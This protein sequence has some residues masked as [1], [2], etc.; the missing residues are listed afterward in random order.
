VPAATDIAIAGTACH[1]EIL[2]EEFGCL[3]SD[4][5]VKKTETVSVA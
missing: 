2:N 3:P 5:V 4:L 1:I